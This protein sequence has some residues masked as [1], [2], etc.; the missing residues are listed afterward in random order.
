MQ[1]R[2]EAVDA[3]VAHARRDSPRECCG[4]LI[5]N[6]LEVFE[7]VAAVNVAVDPIRNYQVSPV[8]HFTQIKR[9][10]DMAS[11]GAAAVNVIGAYHSHPHSVPEP[12]PTDLDGAFGDFL[13]V[14]AGP[15]EGSA[16]LELRAYR[17]QVG[18]FT[19]VPLAVAGL[20]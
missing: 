15:V 9:C 12:S 10:R 14:I 16:Q 1:V 19:D 6:E 18:R 20:I 8:D 7:A 2:P 3:I 17:L 4:L 11:S 13:Y 5:G